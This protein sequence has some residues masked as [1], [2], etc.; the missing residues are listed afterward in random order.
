VRFEARRFCSLFRFV[1]FL[2]SLCILSVLCGN[3]SPKLHHRG[4]E[5]TEI[6]QRLP[7]QEFFVYLPGLQWLDE[8]TINV[9]AVSQLRSIAFGVG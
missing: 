1:F 4:T 9:R 7:D 8:L 6:A 5:F 2:V 3:P